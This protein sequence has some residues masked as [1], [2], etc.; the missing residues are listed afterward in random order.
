[1]SKTSLVITGLQTNMTSK[2]VRQKLAKLYF[3][4]EE[5]FKGVHRYVSVKNEPYVLLKQMDKDDVDVKRLTKLGFACRAGDAGLSLNPVTKT[6]AADVTCPACEQLSGDDEICDH[7]GV[8][9]H[10]Y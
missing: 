10:K 9:I 2:E 1:M 3:L 7:C 4:P 5:N 8:I 6:Q